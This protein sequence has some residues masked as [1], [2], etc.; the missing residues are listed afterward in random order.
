LLWYL[1]WE[2]IASSFGGVVD[3]LELFIDEVA[4]RS[5]HQ[6]AV[7]TEGLD[8]PVLAHGGSNF[9]VLCMSLCALEVE[10]ESNLNMTVLRILDLELRIFK[11]I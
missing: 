8:S 11:Y 10:V 9:T 3:S 1:E 7:A 6:S 5:G 2:I 4:T